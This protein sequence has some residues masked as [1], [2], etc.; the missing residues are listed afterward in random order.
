MEAVFLHILN[1]AI[2]A[3]WLVLAV[4]LLRFVLKKA[5]K[6][7]TCLLWAVVA[8]RL[9]LPF[10]LES[11]LSLIP[12]AEPI[13]QESIITGTPTVNCDMAGVGQVPNQVPNQPNQVPNQT[14]NQVPGQVGAEALAR[15]P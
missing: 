1:I 13:S 15:L 3:S 11:T 5:P 6:W 4:V 14:P 2:T 8:L 9:I 12:D 7:A 10:S